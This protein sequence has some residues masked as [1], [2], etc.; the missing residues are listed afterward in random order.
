M[1]LQWGASGHDQ[2]NYLDINLFS[3][4]TEIKPQIINS[5]QTIIKVYRIIS[6][7]CSWR[8]YIKKLSC[9][10]LHILSIT[11]TKL[12]RMFCNGHVFH[13]YS[14]LQSTFQHTSCTQSL[15]KALFRLSLV[16]YWVTFLPRAPYWKWIYRYSAFAFIY[17]QHLL[18]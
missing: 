3:I 8:E 14:H 5:G 11:T 16:W 13:W 9:A 18:E 15:F 6:F 4:E 10:H 12:R 2:Y 1:G 7:C 17:Y